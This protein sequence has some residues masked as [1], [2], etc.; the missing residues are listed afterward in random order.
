MLQAVV[1]SKGKIYGKIHFINKGGEFKI[2]YH[3]KNMA[4]MLGYSTNKLIGKNPFTFIHPAD[5]EMMIERATNRLKGKKVENE[6]LSRLK[7]K[8]GKYIIVKIMGASP[9]DTKG[10]PEAEFIIA[11]LP[12]PKTKKPRSKETSRKK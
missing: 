8:D 2:T 5:K 7:R 10:D 11:C 12:I 6:Y 1:S 9:N 4:E 3:D